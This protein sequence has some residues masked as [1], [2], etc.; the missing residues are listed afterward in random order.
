MYS[1]LLKV[2]GV[3]LKFTKEAIE[4]IAELASLENSSSENIGARRLHSLIEMLL[5]EVSFDA[6]GEP[7]DLVIDRAYVDSHLAREYLDLDLKR[8]II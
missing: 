1:A 4:R 7:I 2:D 8:Y 5:T 6:H 3:E